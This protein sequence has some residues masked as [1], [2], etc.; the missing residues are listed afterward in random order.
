MTTTVNDAFRVL[1][2]LPGVVAFAWFAARDARFHGQGRHVSIAEQWLHAGLGLVEL[3]LII[4]AFA[5]ASGWTAGAAAGTAFL[6][7][8][9]EYF[10]HRD[11]PAIESDLHAKGHFALFAVLAASYGMSLWT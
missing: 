9:D 4:G 2:V 7:A 5:G 11:I 1:L 6:G 3:V 8:V 10:F